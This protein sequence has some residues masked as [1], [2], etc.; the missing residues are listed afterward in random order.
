M[1]RELHIRNYAIV[2][3]IYLRLSEGFNVITGETGAGKSI[4]MDALSLALGERSSLAGIREGV[5][6][7]RLEAAFDPL[8]GSGL[9]ESSSECDPDPLVFKRV[10]S[11]SGRSRAY[12][13]GSIASLSQLKACGRS[14]IEI[15]GQHGQADLNDLA[16][17]RALLDAFGGL[18]SR[19]CLSYQAR[20]RQWASRCRE[21]DALLEA[22]ADAQ[23][24][25]EDK[26]HRLA[27]LQAA[28]LSPGEEAE[29][30]QETHALEH[31]ERLYASLQGAYAQLSDE[32]GLLSQL[33]DLGRE[34]SRIHSIAQ[35]ADSELSLW[36]Q[37]R[38]Q[39]KE[40]SA[41]LR[42]RI[43]QAT[44]DPGR[45]EALSDRLF[46]IQALKRKYRCSFDELLASQARLEQELE[47]LSEESLRLQSLEQEC[48]D[49]EHKLQEAARRLSAQRG[50][51]RIRLSKRVQEE[52]EGLG[53]EKTRFEISQQEIP[54]SE[55]GM[56]QIAFQISLPGEHPKHLASIASGGELSRIMLAL[57]VVLAE[58]DPVPTL[59]FDEIDAGIGGGIAER[60]GKRLLRLSK[61]HQVLCITHL[62]QIA[63][64]ADAHYFVQKRSKAGRV[65]AEIRALSPSERIE[66]LAR[67]LGGITITP[68]TRSHAEEMIKAKAGSS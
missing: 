45:L 37:A 2:D 26:T 14:L 52:L 62:P 18:S 63:S 61:R 22:L 57:K 17:Q 44:F 23:K 59:V 32:G 65:V 47:D 12:L 51:C 68:L 36:E 21:R 49:L 38:I 33:E 8:P 15:H 19:C 25:R 42:A 48:Q 53:M 67:M 34:I 35:D 3:T 13:G 7:A 50:K 56:D 46:A 1:L 58:S 24:N 28:E 16:A 9:P 60:V 31:W 4:L 27:E 29:L 20:Y 10:L 64:L 30:E 39:L 40:L 43:S 11:K 5:Q 66:E 41:T 55:T 54:L 6:E